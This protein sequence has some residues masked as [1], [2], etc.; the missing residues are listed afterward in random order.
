[1]QILE[2]IELQILRLIF[3]LK[4]FVLDWI[5]RHIQ[6]VKHQ[7]KSIKKNNNNN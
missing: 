2:V 1:M 5:I 3:F 6:V 7:T 4:I